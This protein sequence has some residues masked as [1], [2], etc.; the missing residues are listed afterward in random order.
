MNASDSV[1]HWASEMGYLSTSRHFDLHW[2]RWWNT[3]MDRRIAFVIVHEFRKN[4]TVEWRADSMTDDRWTPQLTQEAQQTIDNQVVSLMKSAGTMESHGFY[5]GSSG[6]VS[7]VRKT[8]AKEFAAW[9]AWFFS[10]PE[11]FSTRFN[12]CD[13]DEPREPRRESGD[14]LFASSFPRPA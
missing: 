7:Y 12:G 9:L 3:C 13:F 5:G 2:R 14:L 6:Y 4:G 10:Q 1:Q 8:A 11:H